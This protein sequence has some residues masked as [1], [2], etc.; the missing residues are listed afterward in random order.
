MPD[1]QTWTWNQGGGSLAAW[2]SV[3]EALCRE[4]QRFATVLHTG[5]MVDQPRTRPAQWETALSV[6]KLLDGCGMPYAIAFGNHDYDN[7]PP[8]GG[9]QNASGD[10]RWK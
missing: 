4:R 5:D 7:Y 8:P 1:T 2:R 3:A 9:D 10:A 6:M